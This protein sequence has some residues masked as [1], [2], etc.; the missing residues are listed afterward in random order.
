MSGGNEKS[1]FSKDRA[2]LFEAL[3]HPTW[4]RILQCL[5]DAPLG[6]SEL[7]RVLDIDSGGAPAVPRGEDERVSEEHA[8]R[9]LRPDRRGQRG[10]EDR[11]SAYPPEN[12]H[13]KAGKRRKRIIAVLAALLVVSV[14]LNADVII[15]A[16]ILPITY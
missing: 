2:E 13:P 10:A 14:A 1:N 12:T 15:Y 11:C 4:I 3:G 5:A 9:E 6:F 7:K 16:Q 8:R